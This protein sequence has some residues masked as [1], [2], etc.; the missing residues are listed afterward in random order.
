MVGELFGQERAVE[1][2]VLFNLAYTVAAPAVFDKK[3]AV[4]AG[5]FFDMESAL[6]FFLIGVSR[7]GGGS[8]G[9]P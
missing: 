6:G 2:A 7:S 8:G 5:A 4:T 9:S 1:D 3:R